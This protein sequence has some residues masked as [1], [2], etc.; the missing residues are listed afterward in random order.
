M[1]RKN[2]LIETWKHLLQ[3]LTV[4]LLC[5]GCTGA[6]C[7]DVTDVI[8]VYVG[9]YPNGSERIEIKGDGS[10]LQQLTV[11]N[12]QTH[13]EIGKWRIS[14]SQILFDNILRAIPPMERNIRIPRGPTDNLSGLWVT[15]GGRSEIV[16][17]IETGYSVQ[18]Q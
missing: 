6:K 10:F 8:G 11:D 12:A 7:P 4:A 5:W 1:V 2:S 3:S 18:K 16:F 9:K 15:L 13:Q 14:G 17:D